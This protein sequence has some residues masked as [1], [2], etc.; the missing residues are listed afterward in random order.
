MS[1][2]NGRVTN[3]DLKATSPLLN[4][5]GKGSVNLVNEKL[6]YRLEATLLNMV[7][8]EGRK[9]LTKLQNT[10]I[11]ITIKGTF[12]DPKFNVDVESILKAKVKQ[13]INKEKQKAKQELRRKAEEEKKKLENKLKQ[14]LEN[15][16][17][18]MLK[19]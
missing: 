8:A 14:G 10:P 4:I 3:R 12:S 18:D 11:P 16:L 7:D 9:A 17:K 19:F 1:I 2:K 5:Q 15:K 13:A 6:D